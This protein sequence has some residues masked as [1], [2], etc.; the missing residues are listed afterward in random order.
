MSEGPLAEITIGVL[1]GG[2][3][4]A[5]NI[6]LG[7]GQFCEYCPVLCCVGTKESDGASLS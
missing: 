7:I 4:V 2:M 6:S 1:G 5:G 3:W